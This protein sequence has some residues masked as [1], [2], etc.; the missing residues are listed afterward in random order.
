MAVDTDFMIEVDMEPKLRHAPE[1]PGQELEEGPVLGEHVDGKHSLYLTS[2]K[3]IG[4]KCDAHVWS[5]L[6]DFIFVKQL[7]T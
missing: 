3:K 7:C 4:S 1:H 2:T 5:E 6:D